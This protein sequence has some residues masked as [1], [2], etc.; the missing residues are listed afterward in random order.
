MINTF[1]AVLV[2]LLLAEK[3]TMTAVESRMPTSISIPIDESSIIRQSR[4]HNTGW[5]SRSWGDYSRRRQRQQQRQRQR[6]QTCIEDT[7]IVMKKILFRYNFRGGDATTDN[8]EETKS[9]DD[10]NDNNTIDET[11]LQK[12]I[13]PVL[14]TERE[15]EEEEENT[16]T[17]VKSL[18][19]L[20]DVLVIQITGNEDENGDVNSPSTT[21]PLPSHLMNHIIQGNRQ[22]K[23]AG[24]AKGKLWIMDTITT[25]TGKEEVQLRRIISSNNQDEN[26][27]EKEEQIDDNQCY[28]DN[29]TWSTLFSSSFGEQQ[30]KIY[31]IQQ[32]EELFTTLSRQVIIRTN[33]SQQQHSTTF[34]SKSVPT[35]LA[36]YL[37]I[38][39]D[40]DRKV[41]SLVQPT[42]LE[43]DHN[44]QQKTTP[45][46]PV[47]SSFAE[48][49]RRSDIIENPNRIPRRKLQQNNNNAIVEEIMGTARRRLEDLETKMQEKILVDESSSSSSSPS[50]F[51]PMPLLEFGSLFK[52]ILDTTETQLREETADNMSDSFRR[53]IIKGIVVEVQRLYIDQLQA[54]RNYYGQRYEAI[55]DEE[56]DDEKDDGDEAAVE[57]RWAI[58]AEHMTTAFQ[59]AAEN[60]AIPVKYRSIVVN[61]SNNDNVKNNHRRGVSSFDHIDALQGLIRDM[62][63]AT[64]R[65]KNDQT[66]SSMLMEEEEEEDDDDEGSTSTTTRKRKRRLHELLYSE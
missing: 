3:W 42:E 12:L 34:K 47:S 66:I 25:S 1:V 18:A 60:A 62:M 4:R 17:I 38:I 51:N 59:A 61:D 14:P 22:R 23:L 46:T 20:C 2:L 39:R 33:T 30:N 64:E 16:G 36:K 5:R 21:Y 32:I 8:S 52:N 31:D 28:S 7:D 11:I 6:Q 10:H 50:P 24:M 56:F 29:T 65:R 35:V 55:L 37:N 54:L 13:L 27:E 57:R 63:E 43:N 41:Q 9:I 49:G 44:D 45:T 26:D 48:G 53:G 15:E 19:L 40:D 58:A